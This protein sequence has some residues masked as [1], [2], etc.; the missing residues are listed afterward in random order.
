MGD[1]ESS[2]LITASRDGTCKIWRV[3]VAASETLTLIST[4]TPCQGASVTALDIL[5]VHD[6]FLC[7]IGSEH[8]EVVL[9]QVGLDLS[10]AVSLS[11]L[12]ETYRHGS[13]VKR[14][15]WNKSKE[16]GLQF[17][18]AGDDHTVRIFRVVLS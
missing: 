12:Y 17:A 2:S 3:D 15:S 4:F 7:V 9:W 10:Q 14:L 5:S 8:G 6:A 11:E 18:S 13:A 1:D 16:N